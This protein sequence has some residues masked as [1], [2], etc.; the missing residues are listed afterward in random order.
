M[1]SQGLVVRRRDLKDERNVI[2]TLTEK[3]ESL[4]EKAASIPFKI[5]Q[6]I[7]LPPEEAK[8]LYQ[9]LYK[10]LGQITPE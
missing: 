6:C 4:K 7:S 5:S 10:I 2:V 8:Q 3:G 9:L 1:E